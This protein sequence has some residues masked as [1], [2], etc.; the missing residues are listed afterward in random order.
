MVITILIHMGAWDMAQGAGEGT[1]GGH[2]RVNK[3][4]DGRDWDRRLLPPYRPR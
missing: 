3:P 2:V 1:E 4:G